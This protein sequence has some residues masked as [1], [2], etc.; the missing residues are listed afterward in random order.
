MQDRGGRGRPLQ[1]RASG[2]FPHPAS[3]DRIS[4]LR[5]DA[6]GYLILYNLVFAL[7]LLTIF[8]LVSYGTTSKQPT[9]FLQG[10]AVLVSLLTPI[11]FAGLGS[12]LL[13]AMT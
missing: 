2:S 9:G 10:N 13:F 1:G 5:I 11:L 8:V 3:S 7:P 4:E 6:I 12:W